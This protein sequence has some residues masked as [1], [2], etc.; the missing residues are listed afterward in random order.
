M[1]YLSLLLVLSACPLLSLD[2]L[3]GRERSRCSTAKPC[4]MGW[5]CGTDGLCR[6]EAGGACRDGDMQACGMTQGECEAGSQVCS[7]GAFGAC[8][9]AV[10]P[11]SEVCDGKDND[12][13][14]TDDEDA[15]DAPACPLDA[16]VCA[17]KRAA[18]GG[19]T[20]SAGV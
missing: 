18:C 13:D 10:G 16:G 9:G 20:C 14:G 11:V 17:G 8:V 6:E 3:E 15:V 4:A 7:S 12:C 2:E 5:T 1:R 19:G